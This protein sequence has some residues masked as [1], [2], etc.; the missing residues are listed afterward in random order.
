MPVHTDLVRKEFRQTDF[1]FPRKRINRN[2]GLLTL[3][4]KTF[5]QSPSRR[6]SLLSRWDLKQ[7]PVG[8]FPVLTTSSMLFCAFE[9]MQ[10]MENEDLQDF[11]CWK[12]RGLVSVLWTCSCA[13]QGTLLCWGVKLQSPQAP[14]GQR[15][16][17]ASRDPRWCSGRGTGGAGSSLWDQVMPAAPGEW[18]W[19]GWIGIMWEYLKV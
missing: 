9:K 16:A 2:V 5:Q 17:P 15:A 13:G 10:C 14:G 1:D 12:C 7:S 19:P 6:C 11:C 4:K 8:D 18:S 3:R